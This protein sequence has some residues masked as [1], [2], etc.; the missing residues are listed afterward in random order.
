MTGL[1]GIAINQAQ[2]PIVNE[3]R[4]A[5]FLGLL[6]VLFAIGSM[7]LYYQNNRQIKIEVR[8]LEPSV[9]DVNPDHE[10]T[11]WELDLALTNRGS[12]AVEP[13]FRIMRPVK[14][15]RDLPEYGDFPISLSYVTPN[16]KLHEND[17]STLRVA[18]AVAHKDLRG[19]R[20]CRD[21]EGSGSWM[22]IF[23]SNG[24]I[25]ATCRL[26]DEPTSA[27]R[28]IIIKL[29]WDG[30]TPNIQ[31]AMRPLRPPIRYT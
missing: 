26:R 2:F 13:K 29:W 21:D 24:I 16:F 19:F 6:A 17:E 28:D 3:H 30:D 5:W 23:P 8:R 31:G 14:G 11:V 9:V 20:F 25:E 18:L 4:P 22:T 1:A 10:L 7:R 27:S 12:R 15:V